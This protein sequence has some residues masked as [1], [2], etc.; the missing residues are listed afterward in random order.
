MWAR[1]CASFWISSSKKDQ[2]QLCPLVHTHQWEG[3]QPSRHMSMNWCVNQDRRTSRLSRQENIWG[4]SCL[5][6]YEFDKR[7]SWSPKSAWLRAG[8]MA[9]GVKRP[10][11]WGLPQPYHWFCDFQVLFG[12]FLT[13]VQKKILTNSGEAFTRC[14]LMESSPP[15]CRDRSS[16]KL[17]L[18]YFSFY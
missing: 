14:H 9:P 17:I 3:P 8:D 15:P 6:F 13:T 16:M 2:L 7:K 5:L 1:H 10:D 12:T 18:I 11:F 4:E